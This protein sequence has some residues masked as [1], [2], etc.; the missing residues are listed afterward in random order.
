MIRC[1]VLLGGLLVCSLPVA[2]DGFA[3][4]ARALLAMQRA[5]AAAS[6]LPPGWARE[7]IVTALGEAQR[8]SR[9]GPTGW[10][11]VWRLV[12]SWF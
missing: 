12:R 4:R 6:T 9:G 10:R 11:R 2:P 5:T 3:N 7:Q 1:F 8:W